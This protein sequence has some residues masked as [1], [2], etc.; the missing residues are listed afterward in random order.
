MANRILNLSTSV[1]SILERVWSRLLSTLC[2][3]KLTPTSVSQEYA[4]GMTAAIYM[5]ALHVVL[6]QPWKLDTDTMYAERC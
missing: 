2:H 6:L 4:F 5:C 3:V 1:G